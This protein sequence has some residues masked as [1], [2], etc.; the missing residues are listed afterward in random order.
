[1]A[2][3][4]APY[5]CSSAHHNCQSNYPVGIEHRGECID[6]ASRPLQAT[7]PTCP[8]AREVVEAAGSRIV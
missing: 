7:P 6:R 5:I 1:M 2:T 8:A 4:V 3:P